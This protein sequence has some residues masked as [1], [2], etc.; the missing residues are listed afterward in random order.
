MFM[1]LG[2]ARRI[3]NID[4]VEK[5]SLVDIDL[6][7]TKKAEA[8]AKADELVEKYTADCEARGYKEFSF[9]LA[10]MTLKRGTDPMVPTNFKR[11]KEF[12]VKGPKATAVKS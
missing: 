5:K 2:V 8:I 6:E 4:R 12:H 3:S 10:V 7:V 11:V 9:D 1:L